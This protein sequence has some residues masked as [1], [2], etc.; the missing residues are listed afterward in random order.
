[1]KKHL[2]WACAFAGLAIATGAQAASNSQD[3]A[4]QNSINQG[5]QQNAA[6]FQLLDKD[7]DGKLSQKELKK[8]TDL[9][10]IQTFN[11]DDIDGNGKISQLEYAAEAKIRAIALFGLLDTDGN[12][13]VSFKELQK[14][15]AGQADNGN[16]LLTRSAY[17]AK[18]FNN[19][20]KSMDTNGDNVVSQSEWESAVQQVGQ[21]Q[22]T[23]DTSSSGNG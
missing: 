9:I 19:M 15:I 23:G 7:N 22:P 14:P 8:T 3:S 5:T 13:S 4:S 16:Q 18:V 20:I 10:A 21:S 2:I 1:M 12:G 6:L 11:I 17:R